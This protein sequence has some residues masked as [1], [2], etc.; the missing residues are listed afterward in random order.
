MLRRP[1]GLWRHRDLLNLRGAET[2]SQHGSQVSFHALRFG[3]SY[4]APNCSWNRIEPIA[5]VT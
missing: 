4:G 5:P 1:R 2:I 3:S